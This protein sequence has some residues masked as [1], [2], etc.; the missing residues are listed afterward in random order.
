MARLNS[1]LPHFRCSVVTHGRGCCIEHS[2]GSSVGKESACRAGDLG[3]IPGSGISPGK[4]NGNPLQYSCLKNSLDRGA[5]HATVHISRV[6]YNLATKPQN[7][8]I[9]QN[10]CACVSC[11]KHENSVEININNIIIPPNKPTKVWFIYFI[12]LQAIER[13][14]ISVV[15]KNVGYNMYSTHTVCV[16]NLAGYRL[17]HKQR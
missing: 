8:N 5:G 9:L 10:R 1:N 13:N 15:L 16:K 3:L 7:L 11:V 6:R 17:S 12:N 14:G 2:P 4:G